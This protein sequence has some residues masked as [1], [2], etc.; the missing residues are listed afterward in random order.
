MYRGDYNNNNNNTS[1]GNGAYTQDG[2]GGND[3]GYNNNR[4]R[5][6][7]F[8]DAAG[9][10]RQD[11]YDPRY[12][13]NGGYRDDGGY[14]K[15]SRN[16]DRGGY[17]PRGNDNYR[18]GGGDD[19]RYGGG[20]R[21]GNSNDRSGGGRFDRYSSGGGV[22]GESDRARAWRLTKKAIVELGEATQMG[23]D[24]EGPALREHI[25]AAA[26]KVLAEMEASDE[27]SKLNHISALTLRCVGKLAHKTSLYAVLVGLV[28]EKKAAFG[29]KM[30]DATIDALQKDADFFSSERYADV[31]EKDD[32]PIRS[33]NN[34]TG[35]ALRMRLLVRFLGE[36][37]S[38]RVLKGDDLLGVLDTLQ[39]VCTPDD[40]NVESDEPLRS[41]E[42]AA[43]FKDFYASV[44]LDTLLHVRFPCVRVRICWS[45]SPCL[46]R[47]HASFL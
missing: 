11:Q 21:Y 9:G 30:V 45:L 34:V 16:D 29:R 24:V 1:G 5:K 40:F 18:R 41:R 33:D 32:D 20:R 44:V 46:F 8:D 37:V 17:R 35:V 13:N 12:N 3:G 47:S 6:R 4:R 23:D 27:D 28:S 36:L 39:S 42:N 7:S 31:Q 38:T 10:D 26:S 22:N 15:R 2:P 19:D 25:E 14:N 43:A